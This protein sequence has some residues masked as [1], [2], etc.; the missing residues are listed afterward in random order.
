MKIIFEEISK[1]FRSQLG[2]E[3]EASR[4]SFVDDECVEYHGTT[5]RVPATAVTPFNKAEPF[6]GKFAEGGPSWIHFQQYVQPDGEVLVT[7]RRG[8]LIDA[9]QPSI[10]TSLT[11]NYRVEMV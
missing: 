1:L 10:N 2:R 5:L 3:L 9:K 8:A 7:V 4:L 6:L 11:Q